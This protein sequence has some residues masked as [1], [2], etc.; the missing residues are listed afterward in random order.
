MRLHFTTDLPAF[1]NFI[2]VLVCLL[3]V[4]VSALAQEN[5]RVAGTVSDQRG[6]AIVNATISLMTSQRVVVATA[7]TDST[8]SFALTSVSAGDYLIRV[9]SSGFA[10]RELLL[11]VQQNTGE[12]KIVLSIQPVIE[13]VTVTADPGQI[14][15]VS[16]TSQQVNVILQNQIRERVHTV[17]AQVATEEV[18]VALQRT[19]PTIGGIYIRGLTGNK[20]N[21]FVD[22]V[23]FSTAA[24]RGGI[25]TFLN[26]ID[27]S[28]LDSI[29]ILRGPMSAQ[30]GG[31]AIG[32]SVQ[33]LTRAPMLSDTTPIFRG[34]MSLFG[35][36]ATSSFGSSMY[37]SY[38]TR[39]LG[40]VADV[41]GQRINNMAA[42]A[43]ID[44]HSAFYRYFG[45]PSNV[46]VGDKTP[47]TAFTPYGGMFRMNYAV[48]PN[49][50]ILT[51]YTRSQIDGGQRHDQLLG[52]DGNL[53]ADLRNFMLDFL[54]VKY[55]GQRVG[56]FDQV[57]LAYSFNSQREERVNQG[58]N[59]NPN[60]T[61]THE[62][63]RTSVNG[64]QGYVEKTIARQDLLLGGEYYHERITA[65][66][67][68]YNPVTG[69]S[70]PR[71]GR[72]PDQPLYQSSGFYLQDTFDVIPN[73]LR[74]LGG[75]RFSAASYSVS[76]FSVNG[77]PLWPSDSASFSSFSYRIGGVYN[78]TQEF[79]FSANLST[80]FRAPHVTD[81]GTLGL[82]GSG[83]EVSAPEVAGLGATVGTTA[84]ADAVS[85][86][87][88]VQQ[89]VPETSLS[90]EFAARYQRRNFKTVFSFFVNNIDNAVTKES[91]IL[92]QGAVGIELGGEPIIAQDPSGV[93]YV[94]AASGPV[95]VRSNTSLDNTRLYGVEYLLDWNITHRWSTGTILTYIHAANVH[96]GLPPN[97][98]G[99]TPAPDMY[100]KLRYNSPKGRW[101]VEPYIHLAA[102]Q[103]R[104][105]T[106]D[107]EDRRTGATRSRSNIGNFFNNGARVRGF[108]GPGGD[109]EFGTSD[110]IL[111]ATGETLS[112]IRN[113][114]LGVGVNAAPLYTAVPG[115]ATF[116]IRGGI[117][118]GETIRQEFMADFQNMADHNYRGI[119]WGMDAP[120]RSLGLR[121]TIQF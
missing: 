108:T 113:R 27:S 91:L 7:T 97:I 71:R 87:V 80:G 44:S 121:Y 13:E 62:Y 16:V 53:I 12:V 67:Y 3:A 10:Q 4:M 78:F 107:L 117:Y 30:Y 54:Y 94:E 77:E 73:R 15:D 6:A 114:V 58:G 47:E 106:L 21:V 74:L 36:T 35:D 33:A 81:L 23:R 46:F 40:M 14:E 41:A 34:G 109:G 98:E 92:P 48:N 85:T 100:I 119:S 18:G 1:R 79:S 72:V 89:I 118:F 102:R 99:G 120:G 31:D 70:T 65:P 68:G 116:N 88:P 52:G 42:P 9:G 56:W 50:Q 39:H 82:T 61:I 84:G 90:Y 20:I 64:V 28:T 111:L 5:Y 110:D 45:V 96:T 103:D 19:S 93:V 51:S 22:G 11:N 8:G 101:W 32:G 69:K 59:G 37:A 38:A 24:M 49:N 29:E 75:L 83:Y 76:A 17:T 86:G 55:Q 66:S 25:N 112:Q 95:L 2:L 115:Y 26:M 43:G 105:S 57:G 104:L 63:E 60:A